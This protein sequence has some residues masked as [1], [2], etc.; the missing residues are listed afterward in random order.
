MKQIK[1][2]AAKEVKNKNTLFSFNLPTTSIFVITI[3]GIFALI[4]IIL[5]KKV[6]LERKKNY[7]K[8]EVLPKAIKKILNDNQAKFTIS[9]LKEKNGLF[10]FQLTW[11]NQTYPPSYITKDGKI[12]FTAGTEVDSLINSTSKDN[13]SQTKKVSCQDIKKTDAPKLTAFIVSDCPYGLQMQRVF[14]QAINEVPEISSYLEVK[15]IGGVT[16]NKITSMHGD[17]EAQ[18][19]LRQICL[20]EEFKNLYW[21][22][23]SCYMQEGRSDEC[24]NQIGIDKNLLNSCLTNKERGLKYAKS[25]FALAD[26][27]KIAGSPTLLIN[28]N[29]VVSEFDFGGRIPDAIKQIVCCGSKKRLDFCQRELSKNQVAVSF[30]KIDEASNSNNSNPAG[31]GH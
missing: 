22:Y 10:E 3:I 8:N 30:S 31:C 11:N 27:F 19:N 18:E 28:D 17:K 9:P 24:L 16:G 14:K 21:P 13:S 20:R 5:F 23:V 25:D 15:Y 6:S 4:F 12:L 1:K 29:Q 7:L 26:K 2:A